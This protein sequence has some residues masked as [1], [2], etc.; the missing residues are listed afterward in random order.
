M[1]F[2]QNLIDERDKYD[3]VL[4]E[5]F[6]DDKTFRNALNQVCVCVLCNVCVL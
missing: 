5:S 6:S 2:V 1:E 4:V 3:R